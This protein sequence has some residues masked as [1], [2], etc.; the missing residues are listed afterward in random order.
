M[1]LAHEGWEKRGRERRAGQK[2]PIKAMWFLAA[3][4]EK[5]AK[6]SWN[7]RRGAVAG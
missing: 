6:L 5:I 2:L 7:K 3:K 4:G 1:G